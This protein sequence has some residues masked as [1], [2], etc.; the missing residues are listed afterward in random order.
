M[1][2]FSMLAQPKSPIRVRSVP[3]ISSRSTTDSMTTGSFDQE[4]GGHPAPATPSGTASSSDDHPA[5][6]PSTPVVPVLVACTLMA[7]FGV[8]LWWIVSRIRR[9]SRRPPNIPV[10]IEAAQKPVLTDIGL[11]APYLVEKQRETEWKELSPM[12]VFFDSN[13]ERERWN[14]TSTLFMDD[15]SS[16]SPSAFSSPA[17][18]SRPLSPFSFFSKHS[19][20]T[21]TI[22]PEPEPFDVHVAM[23]IAM[24][25]Q[26]TG[27]SG[28]GELC[29]GVAHSFVS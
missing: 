14:S 19:T 5:N 24:P 4:N 26:R 6:P 16:L 27:S 18:K 17:T 12:T 29:L 8:L 3:T 15:S 23:V 2:S 10:A 11:G 9:S 20:P 1:K 25:S 21:T 13:S 7:L 22:V 28:S